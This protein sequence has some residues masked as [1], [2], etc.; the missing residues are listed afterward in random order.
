MGMFGERKRTS[1]VNSKPVQSEQEGK[2]RV[3]SICFPPA[4]AIYLLFSFI[5]RG[6]I[7][8][9]LKFQ[10]KARR[11]SGRVSNRE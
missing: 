10:I 1:Y 6:Q 11:E 9:F 7:V 4:P 2:P 3:N 8:N 5:N